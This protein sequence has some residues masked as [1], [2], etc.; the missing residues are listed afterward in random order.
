MREFGKR[1]SSF[2]SGLGAEPVFSGPSLVSRIA[3]GTLLVSSSSRQAYAE[4]ARLRVSEARIRRWAARSTETGEK[5]HSVFRVSEHNHAR[6]SFPARPASLFSPSSA[7]PCPSRF[8]RRDHLL[9]NVRMHAIPS[10]RERERREG[11]V[12]G[13]R[14]ERR[15]C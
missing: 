8:R 6:S 15:S 1:T 2:R 3:G 4:F 5:M 14:Q 7:L 10:G 11:C 9:A 12:D 13:S